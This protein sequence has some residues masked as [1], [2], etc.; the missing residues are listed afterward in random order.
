MAEFLEVPIRK[1][2]LVDA[3]SPPPP[4]NHAS[5]GAGTA[6]LCGG[7]DMYNGCHDMSCHV[8]V[9]WVT[10]SVLGPTLFRWTLFEI[11]SS[12]GQ[13]ISCSVAIDLKEAYSFTNSSRKPKVLL[14]HPP[15]QG[16]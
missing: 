14:L 13:S 8:I 9:R 11:S 6:Q 2:G 3:I 12:R 15:E 10:V 1:A 4:H 16:V 5:Q 7:L